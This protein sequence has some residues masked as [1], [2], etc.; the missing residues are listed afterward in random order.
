[1]G[2]EDEQPGVFAGGVLP[3]VG[4][5]DDLAGLLGLGDLGVGV[6]HLGAGVVLGEEGEH[7]AGALGAARYV[8]FLQRGVL[9]VVADGVEVEVEAFCAAGHSEWAQRLDQAGE[10]VGVGVAAHPVGVGAGVGGLGQRGQPQT[11]REPGVVGQRVDV[12]GAVAARALGQQQGADGLPGGD[13]RGGGVAG[14]GDQ[15]GQA[16]RGHRREQQQQSGVLTRDL[17]GV[18]PAAQGGRLD[19]LQPRRRAAACFVAAGQPGQSGVVEDLPHRLRGDRR[20]RGGQRCGD[21]ADAAVLGAQRQ[22]FVADLAG[23]FAR[24]FRARLGLGEGV[25]FAG[26][27]QGGHLMHRGGG[28]AEPVGHLGGGGLL[29]EVGAQRLVAALSRAAGRGEVLRARPQLDSRS[30][31]PLW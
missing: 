18:G 19:R 28:V 22:Y 2:V 27:Q 12:M 4:E 7:G 14:L 5:G 10:Q 8:V 16:E 1:M 9:A 29:H 21:L 15:F 30:S 26:A 3:V 23:G 17:R 24:P 20:A 6:D 31:M 11:E 13:R 25:E